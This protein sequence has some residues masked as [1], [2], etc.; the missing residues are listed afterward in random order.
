[1]SN[2]NLRLGGK[3]DQKKK[4][5]NLLLGQ[6]KGTNIFRGPSTQF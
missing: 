5:T 3:I 2:N 1:M 6:E 4:R